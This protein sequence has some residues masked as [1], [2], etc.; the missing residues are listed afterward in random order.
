[1]EHLSNQVFIQPEELL[2]FADDPSNHCQVL[3]IMNP[4]DFTV[5]FHSKSLDL[6][7]TIS[8]VSHMPL[9]RF[10]VLCRDVGKYVVGTQRGAIKAKHRFDL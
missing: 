3:T 1:M 10:T 7:R 4:H 9:P 5:T 8:I 2:F 6:K